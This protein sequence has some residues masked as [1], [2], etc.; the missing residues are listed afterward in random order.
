MQPRRAAAQ[1]EA[2][3][4][5]SGRLLQLSQGPGLGLGSANASAAAS[6]QGSAVLALNAGQKQQSPSHS[7]AIAQLIRLGSRQLRLLLT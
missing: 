6:A 7:A 3:I 4:A 1:A 5:A 2:L